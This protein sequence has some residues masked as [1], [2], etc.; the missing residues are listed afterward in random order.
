M[1]K[2]I[3]IGKILATHGLNGNVKLESFCENPQDIFGYTLY[4]NKGEAMPCKQVGKTSNPTI[5]LVKFDNINSIDE[6]KEYKNFEI[7]IKRKDLKELDKNQFYISDLIGK[8]V[9]VPVIGREVSIVGD[10]YV[11]MEIG[12]GVLKITPAHDPNDFEIGLRHNLPVIEVM[13]ESSQIS[14]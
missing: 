2:L 5:F 14:L 6:A 3:L 11:D 10:N 9:I 1:D 13:N 4:N 12:T 7:F 8:K